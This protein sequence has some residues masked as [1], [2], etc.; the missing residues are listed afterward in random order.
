TD[1]DGGYGQEQSPRDLNTIADLQNLVPIFERRGYSEEDI[2]K[3]LSGN[4]VRLLKSVW[5][6]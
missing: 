5:K 2:Q 4:W 1:L 6:R 3:V